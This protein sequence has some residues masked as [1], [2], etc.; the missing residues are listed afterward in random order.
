MRVG[1]ANEE[2]ISVARAST[3]TYRDSLRQI[4][5]A[6]EQAIRSLELLLGRYP[7]AALDVSPQLPRQP[8]LVPAGLPSTLLERRPDVLAA[9]RR[10]AAAFNRVQESEGGAPAEDRPDDRRQ[11]D[12]ERSSATT[13]TG[14]S[15]AMTL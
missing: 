9:Q 11:P 2:D 6:R 13:F 1:V 14:R 10:V 5:F 3:G 12:L 4:E 15:R 7:A 8:D